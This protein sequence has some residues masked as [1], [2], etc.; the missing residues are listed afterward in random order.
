MLLFEWS[1]Y[2]T[3]NEDGERLDGSGF[4]LRDGDGR[5]LAWDDEAL[6]AEG[7]TVFSVAGVSYRL[8]AAQSDGFAPGSLLALV[9]EP[10]NEFD[11]N[12]IG[13]WDEARREQVG[14]VPADRAVEIGER[15]RDQ[16]GAIV[17]WEWRTQGKR[18]ALRVL[19]APSLTVGR[20][21]RSAARRV[22][23]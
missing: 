2:A 6:A 22:R 16:V 3:E 4:Q 21:R 15:L 1:E 7:V 17:L 11:P 19:V 23:A 8:E 18:S 12:A 10:E 5:A 13:V 14:F 20:L 9:P